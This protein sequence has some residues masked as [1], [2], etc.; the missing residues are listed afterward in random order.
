MSGLGFAGASSLPKKSASA[1][2]STTNESSRSVFAADCG[3]V[4][5]GVASGNDTNDS[6]EDAA[7]TG[8]TGAATGV[9]AGAAAAGVGARLVV[10]GLATAA[11][12]AGV[13]ATAAAAAGATTMPAAASL[14]SLIASASAH[15][16]SASVLFVALMST[17]LENVLRTI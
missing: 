3:D 17:L 12:A 8:A 15:S 5:A 6:T 4:D 2:S 7:A 9:G 13:A 10:R 14:A 11:A 16:E 1:P